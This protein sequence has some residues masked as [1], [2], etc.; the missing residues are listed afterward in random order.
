MLGWLPAAKLARRL[1]PFDAALIVMGGIVGSGIFRNPS[2][3][4]KI[5]WIPSAIIGVWIAGGAIS[6]LGAFVIAELAARRPHDGG[7]YAYLRDA[8][9]PL[10]AFMYG[11]T[12]L[13]ASQSGGMA[14]AA[15]TFAGYYPALTGRTDDPLLV[16]FAV[17]ATFTIINCFGVRQGGNLQNVFMVLKIGAIVLLIGAGFIAHPAASAAAQTPNAPTTLALLGAMAASMVA[18]MFA[19]SGWQT[20]SF[21]SGE[22]KNP[23]R[24]L[25]LGL[26]WGVGGVI[27]LYLLVNVVC[28][29][30]LGVNGLMQTDA[31]ASEVARAFM[32]ARGAQVMA[33]IISLSTLGF[34]S[35]QIL[36]SPR[37]YHA[38]AE[39]GLFFRWIAWV[40]P[41]TRVPIVAI[42]LQGAVAIMITFFYKGYSQILGYVIGVDF[43]FFALAAAAIFVFR[44]RDRGERVAFSVPFHPYTTALFMLIALGIAVTSYFQSWQGTAVTFGL[45]AVA[46]P[47]YFLFVRARR[48]A[49]G[50]TA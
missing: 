4:A 38:M 31:P 7:F 50:R 36:T 26:L 25:P 1:G 23:T 16:A 19:Y 5:V 32:G 15:L 17:L 2:V 44:A 40:H 12:L 22:L 8:F 10:V 47:V 34:L 21:M 39:D 6:I 20:A 30:V 33:A 9:H 27:A 11:W 29:R 49:T 42:A 35:N 43:L 37:V 3:V 18:I 24:T 41:K 48:A 45:F 14:A 46:V 13:L 28:L